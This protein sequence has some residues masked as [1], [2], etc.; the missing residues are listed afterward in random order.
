MSGTGINIIFS[1]IGSIIGF[2]V[3]P[4]LG[5]V[6]DRCSFKFGRRRI[7]LL[8]G[9]FIDVIGICIIASSSFI[10]GVIVETETESVLSDHIFGTFIALV[11]LFVSFFGV[12]NM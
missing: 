1:F 12:N 3:Q 9:T 8:V 4:I 7:F 6:G 11:G 10:D 2:F 5:E